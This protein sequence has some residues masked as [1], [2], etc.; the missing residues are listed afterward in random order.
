MSPNMRR[1]FGANHIAGVVVDSCVAMV[2][3]AGDG[4]MVMK[5]MYARR[6]SK[7]LVG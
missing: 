4:L 2:A 6:K 7:T 5:I 1:H 3:F